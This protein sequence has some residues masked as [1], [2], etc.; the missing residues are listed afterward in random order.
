MTID[1]E[2]RYRRE[3]VLITLPVSEISSWHLAKSHTLTVVSSEHEQN[4]KS[5]LQK[6]FG[7]RC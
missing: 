4:F 2:V 7:T 5:V 6:L 1:K 3:A